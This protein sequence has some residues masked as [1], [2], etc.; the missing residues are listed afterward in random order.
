[1][2]EFLSEYGTLII[3]TIALIQPWI[4]FL[5]KKFWKKGKID[6]F[7][8]GTIEVGYSIFGPT[9]GLNGT[10]RCLNQDMFISSIN[11]QIVKQKDNSIHLFDWGV[12]RTQKLTHKGESAELE[13]PYGF[14][15]NTLSPKRYNIVFFDMQTKNEMYNIIQGIEIEWGNILLSAEKG[16]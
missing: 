13:L 10:L 3:A 9:I 12:F 2:K 15:L 16:Y 4:I 11:L 14:M 8:T 7:P 1:M 6:V 5:Y